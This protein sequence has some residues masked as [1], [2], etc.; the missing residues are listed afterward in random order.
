MFKGE[1][2]YPVC[3][4]IYLN[5]KYEDSVR[6]KSFGCLWDSRQNKWYFHKD[7]YLKSG[8]KY[9]TVLHGELC[10]YMILNDTITYV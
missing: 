10:P 4:R 9:S 2:M 5:F 1:K 3:Y 7:N 8:I 6:A